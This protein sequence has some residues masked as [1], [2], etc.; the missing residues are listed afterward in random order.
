MHGNRVQGL[1]H[2]VL[3]IDLAMLKSSVVL[4]T[5]IIVH[6]AGLSAPLFFCFGGVIFG[7]QRSSVAMG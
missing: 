6:P 2:D 3:M 7:P 1:E 4:D 5:L